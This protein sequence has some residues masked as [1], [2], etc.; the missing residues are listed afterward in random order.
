MLFFPLVLAK[1][2]FCASAAADRAMLSG[3]APNAAMRGAEEEPAEEKVRY[4]RLTP[5]GSAVECSFAIK[6]MDKGWQGE[7]IQDFDVGAERVS[8]TDVFDEC[9]FLKNIL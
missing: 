7:V 6:Q 3:A 8:K 9:H 5:N 2:P 4:L 1:S